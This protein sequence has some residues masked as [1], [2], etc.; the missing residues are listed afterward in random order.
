MTFSYHAA[1]LYILSQIIKALQMDL[2]SKL[3]F[4]CNCV[5]VHNFSE[6]K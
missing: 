4:G 3:K 2:Y 6:I 5:K 1:S